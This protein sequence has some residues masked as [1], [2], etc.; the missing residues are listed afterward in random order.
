MVYGNLTASVGFDTK[1]I[2]GVASLALILLAIYLAVKAMMKVRT[3]KRDFVE[4]ESF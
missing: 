3:E 4:A 1:L 2:N